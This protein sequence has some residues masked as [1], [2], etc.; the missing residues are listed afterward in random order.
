[1]KYESLQFDLDCRR[2][3]YVGDLTTFS[4]VKKGIFMNESSDNTF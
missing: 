3:F 1:M 2:L 4:S